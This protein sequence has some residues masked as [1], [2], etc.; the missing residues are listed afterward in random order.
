MSTLDQAVERFK[1]L[2]EK[3]N[4]MTT[5]EKFSSTAVITKESTVPY[6]V[7]K[8]QKHIDCKISRSQDAKKLNKN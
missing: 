8:K 6:S 5:Y 4:K 7:T 2:K 3:L 1:S